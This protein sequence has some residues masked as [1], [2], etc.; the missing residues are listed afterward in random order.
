MGSDTI[1]LRPED[2]GLK[3]FVAQV[4]AQLIEPD[5]QL[6]LHSVPADSEGGRH[7]I[8]VQV[9]VIAECDSRPGRGA[10]DSPGRP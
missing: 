1:R 5:P 6:R 7:F 2:S 3:T 4:V 9:G 8:D 10:G